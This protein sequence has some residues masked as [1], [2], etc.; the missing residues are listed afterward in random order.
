MPIEWYITA[1]CHTNNRDALAYNTDR[2]P[3]MQYEGD[4]EA[5][6]IVSIRFLSGSPTMDG[7]AI[8]GLATINAALGRWPLVIEGLT[9]YRVVDGATFNVERS[10]RN[11]VEA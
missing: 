7:V 8:N 3:D 10:L 6:G 4:S 9:L 5:G 11:R 1:D 2:N